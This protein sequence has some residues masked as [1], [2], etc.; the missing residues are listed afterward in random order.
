MPYPTQSSGRLRQYSGRLAWRAS[1]PLMDE[2]PGYGP[3]SGAWKSHTKTDPAAAA[4]RHTRCVQALTAIG[5]CTDSSVIDVSGP[6]AQEKQIAKVKCRRDAACEFIVC[7]HDRK[8]D[9]HRTGPAEILAT[10]FADTLTRRDL[11]TVRENC[12]ADGR[13]QPV[14]MSMWASSRPRS[15]GAWKT[16]LLHDPPWAKYRQLPG[17]KHKPRSGTLDEFQRLYPAFPPWLQWASRTAIALCLRPGVSE[18]F[19]P[20]WSAFGW[21]AKT[22]TVYMSKAGS[23]KLVWSARGIS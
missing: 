14:P 12:R 5:I 7:G 21:R 6:G 23:T 16:D 22:V 15:T 10:R 18:L 20:E 9:T 4:I 3:Y 13:L 19:S 8:N 1:R 11:E 17:I 2:T